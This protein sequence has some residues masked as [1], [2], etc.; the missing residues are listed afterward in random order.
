MGGDPEFGSSQV[1]STDGGNT[2][3]YRSLGVFYYPVSIGFRTSTEG[4]VPMGEQSFFLYSSDS[5]ENWT[6]LN[7]PDSTRVARV[8]FP[9]STHGYGI[10]PYGTIAK[11]IYQEPTNL[12]ELEHSFSNFYLQQ[13]YPNPFNPHTSINYSIPE[14]GFVRLAVYNM[15]GE[16]VAMI[17]N[18]SQKAGSYEVNFNASGLSSGVYIYR[19]EAANY[20]ASKKLMLMK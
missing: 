11:Y 13:N 1:V 10:G 14:E 17:V 12:T 9:D 3:E 2:W 18:A 7:T 20:T 5:G 6:I 15:L 16:E 4:W 8:C 19:I